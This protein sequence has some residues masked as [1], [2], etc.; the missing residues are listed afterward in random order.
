M[1]RLQTWPGSREELLPTCARRVL[2]LHEPAALQLG[3]DVIHEVLIG[4][5]QDER[6]E[7]DARD[8]GVSPALEGIRDLLGSSDHP[9]LLS[10]VTRQ[11]TDRGDRPGRCGVD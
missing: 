1:R 9:P 2:A 8:A 3:R 4:L 6:D 11:V 5:R 10:V 7:V